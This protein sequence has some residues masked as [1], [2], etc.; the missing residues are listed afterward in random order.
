MKPFAT[1]NR[2]PHVN[3][4]VPDGGFTASFRT[5]AGKRITVAF[6]PYR[7][8]GPPGCVDIKYHDSGQSIMNNGAE[9]PIMHVVGFTVGH[10]TFNTRKMKEPTTL[11]TMLIN[12][13]DYKT[14]APGA[15]PART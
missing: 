7:D 10:D 3:I 6:C 4:D 8:D 2:F 5:V 14:L 15:S 1:F 9:L 13:D 11:I 12:D